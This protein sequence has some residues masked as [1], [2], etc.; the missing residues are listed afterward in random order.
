MWQHNKPKTKNRVTKNTGEN[1][2]MRSQRVGGCQQ[3]GGLRTNKQTNKLGSRLD[4]VN[5]K[6]LSLCF[7]CSPLV[8]WDCKRFK[9]SQVLKSHVIW[10]LRDESSAHHP[11]SPVIK[12]G[13]C[14]PR[15]KKRKKS[16][17][18]PMTRVVQ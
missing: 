18:V 1:I 2:R 6:L 7:G 3:C 4:P 16:A 12:L 15:K 13:V 5:L 9:V 14:H 10:V 17:W 8:Q 11:L